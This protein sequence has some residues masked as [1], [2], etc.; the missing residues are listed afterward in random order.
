MP[1]T[2]KIGFD[3]GDC[4]PVTRE[5]FNALEAQMSALS[6]KLAA[7]KTSVDDL[8]AR[9]ETNLFTQAD[10]DAVDA[11][12]TTVDGIAPATPVEPPLPEPTPEPTPAP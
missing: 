12:K 1:L 8:K 4:S 9:V 3:S 2:I 5:E 7:L 11:L 10:V 6:D